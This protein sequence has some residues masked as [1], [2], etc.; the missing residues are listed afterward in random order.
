VPVIEVYVN[1]GSPDPLQVA[2]TAPPWSSLPWHLIVLMEEAVQRGFAAFSHAAARRHG[3]AW[4]DLARDLRVKDRLVALLDDFE[5]RGYRPNTLERFVTESEARQRWQAL[6][7]FYGARGHF[8]VTNGPYMLEKWSENAV[9]LQVFRD[10]SYPLGVGSYDKYALPAK[11]YL[12]KIELRRDGLKMSAEVEKVE[13]FQRTYEIV[14]EPLNDQSMVGVYRIKPL[15]RYLV[16]T[17]EGEVLQAGTAGDTGGGIFTVELG[18]KLPP[19]RYT[20]LTTIYLNDNYVD[21]DVKLV[22]LQVQDGS[23]PPP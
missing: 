11:A 1:S 21:P 4:L 22:Q 9:V 19:G 14:K 10:L 8:L 5:A 7:T 16:L 23:P 12:S 15:A 18:G 6:K 3:V 13:K 2:A 20:I 17:P